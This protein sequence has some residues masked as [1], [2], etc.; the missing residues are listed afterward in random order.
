[1]PRGSSRVV[2]D[3]SALISLAFGGLLEPVLE[4]FEV[5]VPDVVIEELKMIAAHEDETALVAKEVLKNRANLK[6]EHIEEEDYKPL[7]TSRMDAGEAACVVLARE[8]DV[9]ALIADDFRAMHQLV[10]YSEAYG[11]ALGPCTVLVQALVLKGRISREDASNAFERI[12]RKRNWL[13]RP[14]YR[15]AKK[16]LGL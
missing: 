6:V 4:E 14:I 10:V 8:A 13:G 15:Y 11:F 1:M 2:V 9:E 7:L 12:A 16:M 5:L 3:T